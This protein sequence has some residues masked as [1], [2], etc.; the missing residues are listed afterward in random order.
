MIGENKRTKLTTDVHGDSKGQDFHV[1][2]ESHVRSLH[3][4]RIFTVSKS[5]VLPLPPTG[6][7]VRECSSALLYYVLREEYL[8]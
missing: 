4:P 3:T 6:S 7:T 1:A 2:P 5:L 8:K